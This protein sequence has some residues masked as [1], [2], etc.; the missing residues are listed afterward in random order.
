MLYSH[1]LLTLLSKKKIC[2]LILSLVS[3]SVF[4]ETYHFAAHG[5]GSKK[6]EFLDFKVDDAENSYVL[7]KYDSNVTFESAGNQDIYVASVSA[8]TSMPELS[9][10]ITKQGNSYILS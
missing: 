2:F 10:T 8:F 6:E 4:S 1:Y 7:L 3:T 5:G 9:L